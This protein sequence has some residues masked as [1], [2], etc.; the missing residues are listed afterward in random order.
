[1]TYDNFLGLPE[2]LSLESTAKVIVVPIPFEAS[3][4]YG[5]GTA[6]GPRALIAASQ[7]VELYDREYDREPAVDFGVHTT[8][9]MDLPADASEALEAI[10]KVVQRHA[11]RGKFIVGLG[12]EHTVSVGVGRGLARAVDGPITMVQID[13]HAD[14]RDEY[15]GN[16]FSHACIARRL[17]EEENV[18]QI[19]Q[20][21][22]RSV[23]R[24]EVNLINA[25]PSRLRTWYIEEFHAGAWRRELC[26]RVRGRKVFL[27][28]DVDGLDPA[29]IAATGT[30]EP[31]GL[32]WNEVLDIVRTVAQCGQIVGMDCVELA[33]SP[34]MHASDYA[35]AK[36]VYKAFTYALTHGQQAEEAARARAHAEHEY[37]G[38]DND[39]NLWPS[40]SAG[41]E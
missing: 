27:T 9:P 35:A 18:E 2:E 37:G 8:A 29:I 24:E 31:D 15:E 1:M 6:N 30:P 23:C 7:Q 16:R 41:P 32:Q 21:G 14:L 3:V 17:L 10:A 20:F 28:L 13:A 40:N 39:P 25:E 19:I 5:K 26:D 12:G 33:P 34:G 38:L 36:L 11:G 22:V 4:S